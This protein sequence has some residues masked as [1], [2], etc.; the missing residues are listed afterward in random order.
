[1]GKYLVIRRRSDDKSSDLYED[2]KHIANA[3]SFAVFNCKHVI[4]I[5]DG[6]MIVKNYELVEGRQLHVTLYKDF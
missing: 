1:M 3:D 4:H 2:G 5:R 6:S